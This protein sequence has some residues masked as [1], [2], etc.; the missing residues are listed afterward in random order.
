MTGGF[1]ENGPWWSTDGANLHRNSE[2]WHQ[3][4]AHIIYADRPAGAGYSFSLDKNYSSFANDAT[5]AKDSV[6]LLR[7]VLREHPWLCGREIFVAGESY[8]GH[9]TIQLASALVLAESSLCSRVAGVAIGNGVVDINQTNYAWFEA[10]ATHALVPEQTWTSM[11]R[12][13]DF[14]RD[15]GIDGNGCPSNQTAQCKALL[16]EWMEQSGTQSG[17]LSLYDYYAD[18]CLDKKTPTASHIASPCID[19][20]TTT[21][22]NR[23]DVRAALHVDSRAPSQWVDCSD[24]LNQAYSCSD[25]LVS[26]VPVYS[27]FLHTG[28]RVL[29]YSGD[30]DG[31][32]PT[33]ATLRWTGQLPEIQTQQWRPWE[34]RDGQM[35]GVEVDS[36]VG[37]GRLVVQ[38]V[39]GAGHMVPRFRPVQASDM[40]R[41]FLRWDN[42]TK[43]TSGNV[44]TER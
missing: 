22:L 1:S 14:S 25:T 18:V 37:P 20:T 8:A 40:I 4:P 26:M 6:E 15:L 32:V 29:V 9:F 44:R 11:R 7:Q 10:G 35:A 24:A 28:R 36:E 12:H 42:N 33:L 39:R 21:Y 13:C 3:L 2:S 38:T 16:K 43:A 34:D 23:P 31:I 41:D 19:A 5:T 27:A 30:V 17:L